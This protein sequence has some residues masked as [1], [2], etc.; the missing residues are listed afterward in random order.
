MHAMVYLWEKHVLDFLLTSFSSADLLCFFFYF[1]WSTVIGG[2]KGREM[3]Y[4]RNKKTHDN[5]C[6]SSQAM[7]GDQQQSLQLCDRI[8]QATSNG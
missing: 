7:D 1:V 3:G 6:V 4:R 8:P 5:N 2:S